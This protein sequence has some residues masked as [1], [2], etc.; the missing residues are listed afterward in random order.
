MYETC[1]TPRCTESCTD[2]DLTAL[3]T[4]ESLTGYY[5]VVEDYSYATPPC[6]DACA[7]QNMTLLTDNIAAYGPASV[8]VDASTWNLYTG[9]GEIL[10]QAAC[11]G[12]AYS[13]LD[14]CV[15]LTGFTSEYMVVRNS[16][17]TD[18]G[19]NGYIYLQAGVNTCGVS[20]E[21]TFVSLAAAN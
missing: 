13:D 10:S 18:W 5:A 7:S 2:I 1:T 9:N 6:T 17:A 19:N 16:W 20:N 8:C 12:F 14:H 11:G 3:E 21:A 4:Y 15:Q